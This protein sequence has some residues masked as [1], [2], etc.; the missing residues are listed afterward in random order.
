MGGGIRRS[1][2]ARRSPVAVG[3]AGAAP[4]AAGAPG[5]ATD[6]QVG[7]HW[8]LGGLLVMVALRVPASRWAP[9]RWA[10]EGEG[11][12][13]GAPNANQPPA[14]ERKPGAGSAERCRERVGQA[15]AVP[16]A[17]LVDE[18]L[19]VDDAVD[20][21]AVALEPL[22]AAAVLLADESPSEEPAEASFG[23]AGTPEEEPER[24]S[25]L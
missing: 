5:A 8:C 2:A 6:V 25:V 20:E 4:H 22:S 10:G 18:L 13:S 16:E 21:L 23:R 19:P 7:V 12:R 14:V 15:A 17:V 9:D 3:R 11:P 1:D 24:L